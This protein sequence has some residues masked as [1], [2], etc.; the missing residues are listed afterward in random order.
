MNLDEKMKL[1]EDE[2]KE[3]LRNLTYTAH[4]LIER[5]RFKINQDN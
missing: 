4:N 1:N 3:S 2:I 5:I